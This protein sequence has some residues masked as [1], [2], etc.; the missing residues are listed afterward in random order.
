MLSRATVCFF[1]A[2]ICTPAVAQWWN[3]F[4][5][6]D[7]EE[8]AEGAAKSAKTN[9][10]LRIL[11]AACSSKF[12]GRR[13]LGG[14]YTY[15][16]ARQNR[17]FEIKGP[18]P[19]SDELKFIDSEYASYAQLEM[20]L[21][22]QQ[23]E[24]ERQRQR[25][26]ATAEFQRQKERADQEVRRQIYASEL[27]QRGRVAASLLRAN[28]DRLDCLYPA[29]DSCD[30]FEVTVSVKNT[31][32]EIVT[33]FMVGWTFISQETSSCPTSIPGKKQQNVRLRP[34]DT[35]VLNIKG[36]DGPKSTKARICVGIVSSEI[37]P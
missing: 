23:A 5:P 24:A 3:P 12:A 6:S 1:C 14:T 32:K 28:M 4:A 31:S 8:C 2:L 37:S 27:T 22:A 15:F 33:S 30:H 35:T 20:E 21:L 25:E 9:E 11:I 36:F 34:N 26:L 29:L 16:D 7:Y 18:N 19:T 10:A 17:S 13:K